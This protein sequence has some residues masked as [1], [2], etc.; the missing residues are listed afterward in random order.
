MKLDPSQYKRKKYYRQ[1]RKVLFDGKCAYCQKEFANLTL[2][3]FIPRKKGGRENI[4]NLIPACV[5]CN[6]DKG[7]EYPDDWF[8]NQSFFDHRQW[9]EILFYV[10][11]VELNHL[12]KKDKRLNIPD[13]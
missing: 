7:C 2:D 6:G 12:I 13:P 11:H 8:F 5:E 9:S 4:E 3:H 10:G 1:Q